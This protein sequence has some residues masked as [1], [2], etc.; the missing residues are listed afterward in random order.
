VPG[1]RRQTAQP[2]SVLATTS[3]GGAG[4]V[5]LTDSSPLVGCRV[6]IIPDVDPVDPL[7]GLRPGWDH[8]MRVANLLHGKAA[9]V[10]IVVLPLAEGQDV[11]D[12]L[13]ALPTEW[14]IQQR[15][16]ALWRL[17][18]TAPVYDPLQAG[19]PLPPFFRQMLQHRDSARATQ[20]GPFHS[21]GEVLQ[22]IDV[23]ALALRTEIN[24]AKNRQEPVV[25]ERLAHRLVQLAAECLRAAEDL[26]LL[27]SPSLSHS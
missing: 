21:P 20:P 26:H 9:Q 25:A 14:T 7:T 10:L 5:H 1:P 16:A 3:S 2:D 23:L 13:A 6:A 22:A 19:A 15:K 27:E 17:V 8:A 12:W 24:D 4:K 11:S 18:S